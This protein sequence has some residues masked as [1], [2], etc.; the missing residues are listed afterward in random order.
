[1][2]LSLGVFRI[3]A[4]RIRAVIRWRLKEGI[5]CCSNSFTVSLLHHL[6]TLDLPTMPALSIV[7]A[8]LSSISS[9][10]SPIQRIGFASGLL[11][12]AVVTFTVGRYFI[13]RKGLRKYP[14]PSIAAFTPLWA[15]YYSLHNRRWTA[16]NAAHE[17]LGPIVRLSP[18]HVSFTL[19][20]AL[21]DIY[22][23]GAPI[24]KDHWYSNQA[25]DNPNMADATDKAVHSQKRRTLANVFSPKEV[26]RVEPRIMD[27]TTKLIRDLKLK[28]EGKAVSETDR[29]EV[30]DGVFDA[31]PWLNM[32]SFDA[33]TS[34]VW[35]NTYGRSSV[36][37]FP[38]M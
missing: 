35:S 8:K 9:T 4:A 32:F 10:L 16:V 24:V 22:G 21:R 34:V 11:I 31:R 6:H 30:K 19:P 29:Y 26:L 23:H 7:Y 37:S 5:F 20:E 1:M 33:I 13:D 38:Q 25:G 15:I 28:S 27:L 14:S 2:H 18:N 17:K 3:L 36:R 12:A